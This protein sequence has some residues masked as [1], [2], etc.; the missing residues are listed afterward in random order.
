MVASPPLILTATLDP[1]SLAFFDA[2]RRALFPPERNHLAAHLTLFHALPHHRL[3]E[4][5]RLLGDIAAEHAP[6]PFE[7]TE[8]VSLGRGAA[9]R[10]RSPALMALRSALAAGFAADLTPQDRAKRELHVTVQNKVAPALARQ[11]VERLRAEFAPFG[12][13]AL[14]LELHEYAGGPW[15]PLASF[16]FALASRGTARTRPMLAG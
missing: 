11:T 15:R 12:G 13:E 16:A 1:A 6:I 3:D 5:A 8:V 9:Y 7:A 4:I 10:I 14:G 2:R